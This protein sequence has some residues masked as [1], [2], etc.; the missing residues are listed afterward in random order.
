M[1]ES[2]IISGVDYGPL[3]LLIGVWK[4][5]KGIDLAPAPEGMEEVPYNDSIFFEA[6][7]SVKNARKQTLAA[8]RYHQVVAKNSDGEVFHNESGY[9]MWDPE[10][11]V[12]MQSLTIPRGVCLIAGGT[13]Q[14]GSNDEGVVL[15]VSAEVDS[16]DWAIIQSPFMRENANTIEF[17][18]KISVSVNTLSYHETTVVEIYGERFNHTDGNV[19]MRA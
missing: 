6:I 3:S 12:V 9:W 14:Q 18:H 10:Q 2:T 15:E 1:S 5:D 19:L 11:Q 7:G 13:I 16:P 4:G 17:R 8:L